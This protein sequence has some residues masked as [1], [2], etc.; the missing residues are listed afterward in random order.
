MTGDIRRL[1]G[2][3]LDKIDRLRLSP[4]QIASGGW[5]YVPGVDSGG[6][7]WGGATW[8]SEERSKEDWRTPLFLKDKTIFG[9]DET[10]ELVRAIH[11]ATEADPSYIRGEF[12]DLAGSYLKNKESTD[13]EK[14]IDILAEE[15]LEMFS[16][17]L[18]AKFRAI[19]SG[20]GVSA[21]LSPSPQVLLRPFTSEDWPFDLDPGQA[22]RRLYVPRSTVL[23]IEG[24][25]PAIG[26]PFEPFAEDSYHWQKHLEQVL[27]I[28]R[29]YRV[30]GI[31]SHWVRTVP[32]THLHILMHGGGE[33]GPSSTSAFKYALIPEDEE[34]LRAHFRFLERLPPW[35]HDNLTSVD[36]ALER[37]ETA[38]GPAKFS[39]DTMLYAI[40]G[41]EAL[42]RKQ[43][44]G[45]QALVNRVALL[46][47]LAE[48]ADPLT[49]RKTV[50]ALYRFRNPFVH[51]QTVK[52]RDVPKLTNLL[53]PLLDYL[54][55]SIL[56]RMGLKVRKGTLLRWTD[57]AL[58]LPSERRK[59]AQRVAMVAEQAQ[60]NSSSELNGTMRT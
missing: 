46:M 23:E 5:K 8:Q 21:S 32:T 57:D 55:A 4:R 17:G 6:E 36:I 13:R 22:M 1:L 51:G 60:L 50:N 48:F 34:P 10:Q 3:F 25:L 35:K 37:Y 38:L 47:D 24:R 45:R 41:L 56:L 12:S 43:H 30:G 40:M 2:N 52:R 7:G 18:P 29:L 42:L 14:L 27:R 9:W 53:T 28:L 20:V 15:F 26:Q 31:V 49:V 11:S 16:L 54:R 33:E 39:E 44:E 59:L 19:L 58:L